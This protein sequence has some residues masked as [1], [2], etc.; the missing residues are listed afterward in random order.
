[1]YHLL[2]I[3]HPR[4]GTLDPLLVWNTRK[5][6]TFW[7]QVPSHLSSLP[8]RPPASFTTSEEAKN[9]EVRILNSHNKCHHQLSEMSQEDEADEMLD[10]F[11]LT[12]RRWN[13]CKTVEGWL[14]EVPRNLCKSKGKEKTPERTEKC[15]NK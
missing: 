10:V 15:L 1:M 2:K 13:F 14:R 7:T 6:P 5:S 8:P 4:E 12:D 11:E 9:L 3:L